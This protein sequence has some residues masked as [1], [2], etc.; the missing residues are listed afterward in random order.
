MSNCL[1]WIQ[2]ARPDVLEGYNMRINQHYIDYLK[3]KRY[4][5]GLKFDSSDLDSRFEEF[6][7]TG[8]RIKVEAYGETQFG[9][10]G[11]TTGWK[12]SFLLIHN[13][14]CLGSSTLLGPDY[15]ILA[16]KRGREYVPFQEAQ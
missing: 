9:T 15:K 12:P 4:E 8:Q 3:R 5:H 13:S 14:R 2:S 10:V 7:H 16:V 1:A 11:A 6:Y